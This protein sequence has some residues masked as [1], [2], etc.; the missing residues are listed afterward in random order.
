VFFNTN[1]VFPVISHETSDADYTT[2]NFCTKRFSVIDHFIVSHPMRRRI[3]N[4]QVLYSADSIII[5]T[6]I[7]TEI[8]ESR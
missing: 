4:V 3:R 6:I 7:S 2:Y 8:I 5:I 1:N